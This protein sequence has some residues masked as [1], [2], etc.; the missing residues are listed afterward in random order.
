[1]DWDIAFP[2]SYIQVTVDVKYIPI[3]VKEKCTV[4]TETILDD[5]RNFIVTFQRA[6][7][8]SGSEILCRYLTLSL[9]N[10][11]CRTADGSGVKTVKFTVSQATSKCNKEKLIN[12][13][14][15]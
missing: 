6:K 15:L 7:P 4:Y 12:N 2:E 8:V 5:R 14:K 13:Y 10:A 1:M 3:Y 9:A 11:K